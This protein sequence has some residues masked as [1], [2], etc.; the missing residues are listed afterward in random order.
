MFREGREPPRAGAGRSLC[1]DLS[2]MTP[3]GPTLLLNSSYEP[4]GV[5]A[6]Q[7]AITMLCLGKVEVVKSYE[8]ALR[9]VSW[10]VPMPAVV[11]LQRFVKRHKV[12]IALSRRNVFHR[13]GHRCQYCGETFPAKELT[14]DHVIPRSQGGGMSWENLVTACAPCNRRKGGRTP[15]EARMALV[16]APGRP[17]GLAPQVP[18]YGGNVPEPWEEFLVYYQRRAKVAG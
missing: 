1:A 3:S 2:A 8:A 4:L 9:A 14:C 18:L 17:G 7:R 16:K 11:R 15:E 12:R 6:W 10:T 5:I 13:D